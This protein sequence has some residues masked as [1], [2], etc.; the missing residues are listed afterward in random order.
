M[1]LSYKNYAKKEVLTHVRNIRYASSEMM[2]GFYNTVTLE[3][4]LQLDVTTL[5]NQADV[6]A[7]QMMQH[8][9]LFDF[10]RFLGSYQE[11]WPRLLHE[12]YVYDRLRCIYYGYKSINMLR[13]PSIA[14]AFPGNIILMNSI[15][16]GYYQFD[17]KDEQPYSLFVNIDKTVKVESLLR[18]VFDEYPN[19]EE[20]ISSIEH[21]PSYV[22]FTYE[23]VLTGLFNAKSYL[24]TKRAS[25]DNLFEIKKL[26]DETTRSMLLNDSNPIAN[27]FLN[28]EGDKFF[29]TMPVE[30]SKPQGLRFDESLFISRALGFTSKQI[31]VN[32]NNLYTS[33]NRQAQLDPFTRDEVYSITG[34]KSELLPMSPNDIKRYLNINSYNAI[35]VKFE[36]SN[37]G[38]GSIIP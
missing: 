25:F 13:L 12:T 28:T 27:S 8:S 36:S 32:G 31:N 30:R 14:Y 19:L 16:D 4:K 22:N 6:F 26:D 38:N 18:P 5:S 34:L 15:I 29:F 20:G 9:S 23:K 1:V 21:A 2:F 11:D 33:A 17:S 10:K 35:Q 3:L 7:R 37:G 24:K